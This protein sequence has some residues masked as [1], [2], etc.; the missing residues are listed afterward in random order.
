[1]AVDIFLKIDGIEGESED[2]KHGKEIQI[3]AWSWGMTQIGSHDFG[4]GGGS[5][6]VSMQD[7]NFTTV[8]SKAT[9]KLQL[10]CATGKHIPKGVLAVRKA[11]GKQDDYDIYTFEDLLISSFQT[12]GSS[13]EAAPTENISFNYAKMKHEYKQQDKA[14]KLTPAGEF[15]YD[16]KKNEG[17]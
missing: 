7:F 10:A 1:M 5:G 2:S 9:T 15:K 4:G 13:G 16:L 12:G 3:L 8:V 6:K 11:G 17:S 14:G